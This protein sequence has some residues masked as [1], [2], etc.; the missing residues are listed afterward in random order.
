MSLHEELLDVARYLIRRNQNRPTQA[1]L[2]RSISTAYYGLFHRLIEDAVS[3][4]APDPAQQDALGRAFAHTEMKRVCQLLSK[5]PLPPSAVPLLGTVIPTD[6][7]DVASAFIQLQEDR[8]QADYNRGRAFTP[9][10]ARDAIG[11][12]EAT[13][14]AW[15]RVRGTPA[16]QVF[17]VLLLLGERWN[18]G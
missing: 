5:S 14:L 11:R 12:V 17:L 2:R 15:D 8:H 10:E 3:R 6:L 13:I 4:L 7:K 9:A 1:D 18:R 16:A